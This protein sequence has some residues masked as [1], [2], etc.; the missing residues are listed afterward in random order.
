MERKTPH[1]K[2]VPPQEKGRKTSAEAH[3]DNPTRDEAIVVYQEAKRKL[4]DINQWDEYAG[5]ASGT[6][7]LT[8]PMGNLVDRIPQMGDL[9]RINIP[10]PGPISGDGYDWV[11]IEAYLETIDHERDLDLFAF[12]VRPVPYPFSED[13]VPAHFYSDETTSTFL[14]Q[15]AGT[16]VTAAEKGR[17]EIPNTETENIIDKIR[18]SAVAF[19]ASMG[20]AIPQWKALM[21]GILRQ[22]EEK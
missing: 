16:R 2:I 14:L 3:I 20:I 21:E 5:A 19:G 10:G 11:C 22:D 18:N 6:F 13:E 7:H 12:R 9:I 15:R 4:M 1:T 17:N 8:D